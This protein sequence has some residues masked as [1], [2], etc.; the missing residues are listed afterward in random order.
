MAHASGPAVSLIQHSSCAMHALMPSINTEHDELLTLVQQPSRC[1]LRLAQIAD[2]PVRAAFKFLH[3]LLDCTHRNIAAG[4]AAGDY[5]PQSP[6]FLCVPDGDATSPATARVTR[7][8]PALAATPAVP[9]PADTLEAL[10]RDAEL[11]LAATVGAAHRHVRRKPHAFP[12][13][14]LGKGRAVIRIKAG[15]DCVLAREPAR[16]HEVL[17][18]V[19]DQCVSDQRFLITADILRQALRPRAGVPPELVAFG[20][21]WDADASLGAPPLRQRLPAGRDIAAI[22][23]VERSMCERPGLWSPVRP[24]LPPPGARG[25]EYEE[26][27]FR[28]R[29]VLCVRPVASR[30]RDR[31]CSAQNNTAVRRSRQP[32]QTVLLT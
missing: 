31:R 19:P 21:V 5:S 16:T 26:V 9:R 4:A 17:V 8:A 23:P 10:A 2:L 20:N 12:R 13:R 25:V 15:C 1:R 24:R 11:Q 6:E 29:F 28:P 32:G 22:G 7:P 18:A 14:L 3:K 30:L 27:E